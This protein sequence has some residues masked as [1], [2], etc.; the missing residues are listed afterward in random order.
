M[1]DV[2]NLCIGRGGV[3]LLAGVD[4]HLQAGQAV[5]LTGPNGL[6]KT[7]LLRTLAGLQPALSG[8]GLPDP[9]TLAYAA[10]SDGVKA[11]LTVAENL[12]FWAQV[13]GVDRFETALAAFELTDLRDRLEGTLSAGQKRRCGLARLVLSGR[14]LWLLDEPTVSLDTASC[15]LLADVLTAHLDA[16]GACVMTSHVALPLKIARLDLAPFKA[17]PDQVATGAFDEALE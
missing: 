2:R 1:L 14:A 16:G 6:G 9:E 7:T 13:S 8:Q 3:P 17:E 4:L 10:H 5:A 11:T 15:A 12:S